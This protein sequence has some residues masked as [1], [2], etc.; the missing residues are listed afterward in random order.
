MN[1][2]L[3]GRNVRESGQVLSTAIMAKKPLGQRRLW[4]D[5]AM[6]PA[7]RIPPSLLRK[8][9][10]RRRYSLAEMLLNIP[11]GDPI[12]RE[13]GEM[14]AVGREVEPAPATLRSIRSMRRF[15][16]KLKRNR[17]A[18]KLGKGIARHCFLDKGNPSIAGVAGQDFNELLAIINGM[19]ESP[20]ADWS[21]QAWLKQWLLRPVPALG[22]ETP[23]K[24]L[25]FP[26][27]KERIR[28]VLLCMGSGAYL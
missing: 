10:S 16:R 1:L 25:N 12:E 26:G 4:G 6:K 20:P 23:I 15:L 3:L 19:I 11:E 5:E 7:R 13:W 28:K 18:K 21:A 8:I 24:V 22:G 14:P 2:A 9:S 27:G 17:Q